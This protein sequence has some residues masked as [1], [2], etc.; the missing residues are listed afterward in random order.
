VT[1]E[2]KAP[3][4]DLGVKFKKPHPEDVTL[5]MG[6]PKCFHGPFIVDSEAAEVACA[7][8]GEKLN[9]MV[10]LHRLAAK[11]SQYHATAKRYQEEMKRISE[12]SSTKCR[13]CGKMTRISSR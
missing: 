4:I 1:D 11:E 8:C 12:R 3:V 5:I 2:T 7:T 13:H 6:Y 9:P 10:V